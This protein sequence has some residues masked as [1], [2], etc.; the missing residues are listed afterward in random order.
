MESLKAD[1]LKEFG[2][3]YGSAG[4]VKLRKAIIIRFTLVKQNLSTKP[5]NI[6]NRENWF[7]RNLQI[8]KTDSDEDSDY[9]EH[10]L[11]RTACR[12]ATATVASRGDPGGIRSGLLCT[13]LDYFARPS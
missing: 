3:L 11:C 2:T 9:G 6:A 10:G 5:S 8:C 12:R 13:L 7:V 1:N 4:V